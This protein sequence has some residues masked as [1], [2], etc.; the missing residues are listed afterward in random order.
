MVTDLIQSLCIFF[1]K[2]ENPNVWTLS[3]GDQLIDYLLS[4]VAVAHIAI[5]Q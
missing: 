4:K 5:N 3:Y 1:G 2:Y